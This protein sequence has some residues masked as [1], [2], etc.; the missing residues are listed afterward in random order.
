MLLFVRESMT[1]ALGAAPYIFL[2][3]ADYVS[4]E[5]ERP[6]AI[7]WKLHRAMPAEVYLEA[8]AAVA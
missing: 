7:T 1:N 2:G 6:V 5:G 3:P 4:H 8:R